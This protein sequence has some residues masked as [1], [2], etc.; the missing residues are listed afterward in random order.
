MDLV[1]TLENGDRSVVDRQRRLR[2]GRM[3]IGRATDSDWALSDPE[4][5]LS[6]HHCVVEQRDGAWFLTDTS[7]NGVFVD[8]SPEPLGRGG[9]VRLE[10]GLRLELGDHV[11]SVRLVA[12]DDPPQA[13]LAAAP[14]G[15]PEP[16]GSQPFDWS[17]CRGRPLSRP[18]HPLGAGPALGLTRSDHASLPQVALDLPRQ[19]PPF[20]DEPGDLQPPEAG[21][22]ARLPP[23]PPAAPSPAE[24]SSQEPA[25]AGPPR[26]APAADAGSGLA[27]FLEGAGLTRADAGDAAPDALL[28]DL[29]HRYRMMARGLIEL[30]MIRAALKREAGLDRTMIAAAEN[31][32]LKLTATAE[33]AVRWLVSPRGAGYLPPDPAIAATID[34]LKA[35]MPELVRSMQQALQALL[36]RF[37]PMALEET[38]AHV[39]FLEVIAAGG[40]KAAYWERFKER[41]DELARQAEGEF[42]Q[43]VGLDIGRQRRG[44]PSEGR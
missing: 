44:P 20:D 6:K 31:N 16:A 15:S 30:L 7:A 38:L 25:P 43:Q 39:S 23:P 40:R 24:P 33:E 28:R 37:D 1:L 42:L 14:G 8:G 22:E 3:S 36:R 21:E 18:E 13:P 34:D 41:Y 4:R 2:E 12:K 35:F 17:W 19:P 9:T 5:V 10:D 29:G 32:P 11:V 26:A 27:A